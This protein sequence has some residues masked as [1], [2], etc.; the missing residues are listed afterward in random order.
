VVSFVKRTSFIPLDSSC[1]HP[2]HRLI[3]SELRLPQVH[4]RC[5][6]CRIELALVCTII[7][8]QQAFYSLKYEQPR[9]TMSHPRRLRLSFQRIHSWD[10][11]LQS[12][13]VHQNVRLVY[14]KMA[15]E[16]CTPSFVYT[17]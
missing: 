11:K 7:S 14:E 3:P 17:R 4:T 15:L 10:A 8:F 6:Q 16:I 2:R 5:K 13:L 12:L 9:L 1:Q